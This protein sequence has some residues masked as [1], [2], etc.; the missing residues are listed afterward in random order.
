LIGALD[1]LTSGR[2]TPHEVAYTAHAVEVDALRQQS[3]IQDQLCSAFGGINFIEMHKYPRAS[4][5]QIYVPNQIW[6]E[7]ERRLVLV[8]LGKSHDSSKIH[9]KVIH[10]LENEGPGSKR[11]QDLRLTAEKSRDAVYAG[12]FGA[13]GAAMIENTEAQSR[14]HA[15]LVSSDAQRV[16]QIARDHGAIGWKVNGAGGEGGSVTLLCPP[17]S[18]VKRAMIREIEGDSPLYMNIPI[19]LSRFGLRTWEQPGVPAVA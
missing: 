6:W 18:Y 10:E 9:E 8:F 11:L 12:D 13:L 2:L 15:E 19:Y 5:S 4:I 7:L 16:I 3:G 1:C 14:L 17:Q